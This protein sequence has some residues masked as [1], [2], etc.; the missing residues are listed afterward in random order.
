MDEKASAKV[1]MRD[2]VWRRRNWLRLA[3]TRKQSWISVVAPAALSTPS[4]A[5]SPAQ[6]DI[7]AIA[8]TSGAK[9]S[10]MIPSTASILAST[11]RPDSARATGRSAWPMLTRSAGVEQSQRFSSQVVSVT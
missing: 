2:E 9:M 3:C 1:A 7:A 6:D 11:M 5:I 10:T 4:P 8:S